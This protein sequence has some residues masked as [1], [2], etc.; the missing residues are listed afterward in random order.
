MNISLIAAVA[1]NGVIGNEGKLAWHYP[2]DMKRFVELTKK[3]GIVIMGRKTHESIGKLLPGRINIVMSRD[4]HYQ[5]IAGALCYHSMKE[6]LSFLNWFDKEVMVIGG[7]QLYR[8]FLPKANALYI[9]NINAPF[10]GDSYFP[11]VDTLEWN[12]VGEQLFLADDKHQSSYSFDRY[13]RVR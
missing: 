9:T 7:E 6:V 13:V 4:R 1:A 12:H 3:A 11:D 10:H 5:P 2:N 8:E